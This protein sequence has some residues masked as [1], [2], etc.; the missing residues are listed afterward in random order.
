VQ[1]RTRKFISVYSWPYENAAFINESCH[2]IPIPPAKKSPLP[3]NPPEIQ[4]IG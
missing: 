4:V 1:N 3:F 2:L